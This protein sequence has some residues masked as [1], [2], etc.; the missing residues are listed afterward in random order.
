MKGRS[1]NYTIY[2]CIGKGAYGEVFL[3]RYKKEKKLHVMKNIRL[4]NSS[5]KERLAAE[6]EASLLSQLQHPNIVSYKESFQDSEG[7]LHIVMG[8][9][10]GGDLC[11]RLKAQNGVFLP[12]SQVV[13]WFVQIA[14]ALQYLHERNILHRDLK[15]QNIF[16]TKAD[17]IKVGDLGIARVLDC[18]SELAQTVIGT[19]YYMSPEIFQNQ[20]YNQKSD[21]W[22][23]GCCVYEMST[24]KHAFTAK[25]IH[26]LMIRVVKGELPEMPSHYSADV[27]DLIKWMLSKQADDRPCAPELLRVPFVRQHIKMF[28]ERANKRKQKRQLSSNSTSSLTTDN[29][30][31]GDPQRLEPRAQPEQID[32]AGQKDEV[33]QK[34]KFRNFKEDQ[35][36]S[37]ENASS[38][39]SSMDQQSRVSSS[40]SQALI[41]PPSD[42]ETLA[43]SSS[44]KSRSSGYHS[45]DDVSPVSKD[46]SVIPSQP[47]PTQKNSPKEK[48]VGRKEIIQ[49]SEKAEMP[50]KKLPVKHSKSD[51]HE[52]HS[53]PRVL[54]SQLSSSPKTD[55]KTVHSPQVRAS[56]SEGS[57]EHAQ[58]S[59]SAT[60]LSSAR[61]RRRKHKQEKQ[62]NARRSFSGPKMVLKSRSSNDVKSDRTPPTPEGKE[63]VCE[64]KPS[65]G[66]GGLILKPEQ[67]THTPEETDGPQSP[68]GRLQPGGDWSKHVQSGLQHM[69][70]NVQQPPVDKPGSKSV[71]DNLLQRDNSSEPSNT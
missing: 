68:E 58:K 17:I 20:A 51:G 24:L 8:Y 59:S 33:E 35:S 5:K 46:D 15:T 57:D 67:D 55:K 1:G 2:K 63:S 42:P 31:T 7:C 64:P 23:L 9:C 53:S 21:I 52:K 28:L 49:V 54:H 6:R 62:Q 14:L 34:G 27:R 44:S 40:T 19:P 10:E 39:T 18:S 43:R 56:L 70:D 11:T 61:E 26:A 69:K 22:A 48:N 29:C 3:A 12:E 71:G 50:T 47:L 25:N 16:L 60:S 36:T 32:H 30:T 41:I 66:K 4:A 45:N 37:I 38:E 13:E 65:D